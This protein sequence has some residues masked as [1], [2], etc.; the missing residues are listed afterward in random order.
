MLAVR[1]RCSNVNVVTKPL[2]VLLGVLMRI[3]V[4]AMTANGL[5]IGDVK[6]LQNVSS[7]VECW[8]LLYCLFAVIGCPFNELLT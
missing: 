4:T 3:A 7:L 8:W 5:Q 1:C 6:A 2:I